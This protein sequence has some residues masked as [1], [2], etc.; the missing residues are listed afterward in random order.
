MFNIKRL[1]ES[2]K[3]PEKN[4]FT[5]AGYD[6]FS[7]QNIII[8]AGKRETISIGISFSFDKPNYL[9]ENETIYLRVAPRSGLASKKGIDVFAGV[10][11]LDY[12]GELKVCLFNSSD[13]DFEIKK[14]DKIAQIIPTI[15]LNSEIKEVNFLDQTDRGEKGFGSSGN[16]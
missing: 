5:D 8:P 1:T 4:N 10:I 16:K 7:D 15:I 14:G 12:R 2:A 13:I 9:R 11:D 6:V 3:L